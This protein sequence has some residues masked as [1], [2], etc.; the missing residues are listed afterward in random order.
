MHDHAVSGVSFRH[1]QHIATDC[2][3]ASLVRGQIPGNVRSRYMLDPGW[4]RGIIGVSAEVRAIPARQARIRIQVAARCRQVWRITHQADR[5]VSV[6]REYIQTDRPVAVCVHR[7]TDVRPVD[8][9]HK[10]PGSDKRIGNRGAPRQARS[11]P[12]EQKCQKQSCSHAASLNADCHRVL[13][14]PP[15][16]LRVSDMLACPPEQTARVTSPAF[17]CGCRGRAPRTLLPAGAVRAGGRLPGTPP[18]PRRDP[19]GSGPC[20]ACG[21]S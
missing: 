6:S 2:E 15:A 7:R 17:S 9:A 3:R 8:I 10:F 5:N 20:R 21:W 4:P 11:T 13:A 18:L 12:G 16:W 14:M 1:G 19:G